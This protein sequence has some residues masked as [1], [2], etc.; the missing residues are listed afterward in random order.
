MRILNPLLFLCPAGHCDA[1]FCTLHRD[2]LPK[3]LNP[4]VRTCTAKLTLLIR[5]SSDHRHAV[6]GLGMSFGK[7]FIS[8]NGELQMRCNGSFPPRG[9]ALCCFKSTSPTHPFDMFLRLL[10]L[11]P[12]CCQSRARIVSCCSSRPTSCRCSLFEPHDD[13]WASGGQEGVNMH[14]SR[15]CHTGWL[16]SC[17]TGASRQYDL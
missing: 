5:Q 10:A 15:S 9:G 13:L 12:P 2:T 7:A 3:V 16:C 8:T 14:H 17:Y 4:A 6:A 11:N 1:A